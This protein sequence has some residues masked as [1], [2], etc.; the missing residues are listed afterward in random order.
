MSRSVIIDKKI[1]ENIISDFKITCSYKDFC[2][3]RN[4]LQAEIKNSKISIFTNWAIMKKFKISSFYC[5]DL[6]GYESIEIRPDRNFIFFKGKYWK[7]LQKFI[8]EKYEVFIK[9][10]KSN[11]KNIIL[12]RFK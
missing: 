10:G 1:Y 6:S 7:K 2:E 4:C 3:Y 12:D 8:D 11:T 5:Y 9:T